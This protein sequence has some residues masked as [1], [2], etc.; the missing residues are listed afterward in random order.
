MKT[1]FTT[2][3]LAAALLAMGSTGALAQS[4]NFVGPALGV[5]VGA[6]QSRINREPAWPTEMDGHTT[7][8]DLVGSWGFATG[9]QWVTTVGM[10]VGLTKPEYYQ[11]I[12]SGVTSTATAKQ[13]LAVYVAPGYRL[14][15]NSLVYAKVGYHS[16]A[17]AYETSTGESVTPTHQGYGLGIGYAH[18][19]TSNVELRTEIEAISYDWGSAF[20]NVKLAP[21][22]SNLNFALV[23]K[24]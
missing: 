3:A 13:H 11:S 20:N 17:M 7:G 21:K 6:Q 22:Q 18:A 24:F 19:L 8:V 9:K 1:T 4:A 23:Y 16:L 12:S 5:K 14:G 15:A 10:E 2:T